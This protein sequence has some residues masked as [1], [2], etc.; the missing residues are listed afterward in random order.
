MTA[1]DTW[2]NWLW[3]GI[4][5]VIEKRTGLTAW[6][7]LNFTLQTSW[8]VL[9]FVVG[10]SVWDRIGPSL[11]TGKMAPSWFLLK[12]T[13]SILGLVI[14]VE[15]VGDCLQSYVPIRGFSL[16][17]LTLILILLSRLHFIWYLGDSHSLTFFPFWA[18]RLRKRAIYGRNWRRGLRHRQSGIW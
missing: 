17:L 6:I 11:Y 15:F 18:C 4:P 14:S 13:P 5:T 2:C 10:E 16:F 9:Y 3:Q 12:V 7:R 8:V 1:A